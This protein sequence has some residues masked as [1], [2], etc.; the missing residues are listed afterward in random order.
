MAI[1]V[2]V[3]G[4]GVGGLVAA[5]CLAAQ[6]VR[7]TLLEA[8]DQPGGK[9]REVLAGGQPMD[10]GPTVFTMRWV[11]D[12]LFSL[13]GQRLDDHLHLEPAAVLARHAWSGDAHLDL[14]AD[15]E[16]SVDAIGRFAGAADARGYRQFCQRARRIYRTL[17][18][19][20]IRSQRP[21]LLQL[22]G[23]VAWQGLPGL[24][25][26]SPFGTLAAALAGHFR[27]ARL[28]QLF[29]RYATY[30]GSSPYQAPATLMLV[31][32]VEHSGV[33]YVDGGMHRLA[34]VLAAQAA[35]CGARLRHGAR[36]AEILLADGHAAGVRLAGGEVLHADA[37]VFNGD[38]GALAAGHLGDAVRAAAGPGAPLPAQRSLS[39]VTW[40]LLA[41]CRGQPLL[42]HNV[43][44]SDDY[45]AE[46]DDLRAGRLPRAPTV[47][48]CAQDRRDQPRT[49]HGG[50]ERLLMLVNAPPTG[51]S[52]PPTPEEMAAC[53]HSTFDRLA[54]CG[55]LI[56]PESAMVTTT[57]AHFERM[58]PGTGGALYGPASH[59]WQASFRRAGSRSRLPG[60]Y[61]AGGSTHPGPGV[62]MAALS[63][64]LAAQ[65]LLA[66]LASMRRHHPVVMPGGTS[67]P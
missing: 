39:A 30:C 38:V 42:R 35:R 65:R 48:L 9:L 17:E 7:V 53:Q 37:V 64:R 55:L 66:D 16:A 2:V 28:R 57:P 22:V 49:V 60:L 5:A 62:P 14:H 4:A 21:G 18:Q 54:R 67:M 6:G 29:G 24:A 26:I 3:I 31:A 10:A 36:V 23:R 19:P 1:S 46:F 43:C 8:A 40:N 13:L 27:D 45:R 63:G 52:R 34:Q 59:G 11:F 41:H 47:Y 51:D 50:P 12:E 33:W 20:F 58:F 44:F 32:H 25:R 15:F 61:L 56:R